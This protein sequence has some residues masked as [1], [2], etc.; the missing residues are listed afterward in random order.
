MQ[1][2]DGEKQVYVAENV[3][4]QSL[5]DISNDGT[6]LKPIWVRRG[7]ILSDIMDRKFMESQPRFVFYCGIVFWTLY[8]LSKVV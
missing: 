5:T 4:R 3:S 1:M 7:S 2:E 8:L 6:I